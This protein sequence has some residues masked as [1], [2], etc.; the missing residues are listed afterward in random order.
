M[1][2]YR[3]KYTLG[4]D[5]RI[6]RKITPLGV[7]Y[8]IRENMNMR[9]ARVFEA[10]DYPDEGNPTLENILADLKAYTKSQ[11]MY[12]IARLTMFG[13]IGRYSNG[14]YYCTEAG[15]F[16]MDHIF[17]LYQARTLANMTERNFKTAR[18]RAKST[19]AA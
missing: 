14:E 17:E 13:L 6:D 12:A 10:I 8:E 15:K 2:P 9:L 4:P 16:A 7:R 3:K 5:A 11:V 18:K 19:F 1:I